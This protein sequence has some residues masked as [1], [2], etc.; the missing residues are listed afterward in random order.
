MKD[1]DDADDVKKPSGF[2][3]NTYFCRKLYGIINIVISI[4]YVKSVRF[5]LYYKCYS[6]NNMFWH[7]E[8][9]NFISGLV[10]FIN[11]N[12]MVTGKKLM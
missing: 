11:H 2:V 7:N 6:R 12:E 9:S 4:R 10:G 3:E 1:K 8:L 5:S